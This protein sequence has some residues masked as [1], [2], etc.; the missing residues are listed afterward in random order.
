MAT[1]AETVRLLTGLTLDELSATDIESFLELTGD[2]PKL[3]A[4]EAL[5]VFAGTLATISVTSDDISLDGSKRATLLM[6]R[7][8]RLRE[9]ADADGFFFDTVF[10]GCSAAELTERGC[11]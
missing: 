6:Q 7:A 5:E 2:D 4:A 1:T 8:A 11:C 9:Q 10:D 3:A